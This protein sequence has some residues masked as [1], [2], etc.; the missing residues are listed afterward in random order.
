MAVYLKNT[1]AMMK[2]FVWMVLL[3]GSVSLAYAQD[4]PAAKPDLKLT[5]QQTTKIREINKTYIDGLKELRKD[6][7]LTKET[8]KAQ[9]DALQSARKEQMQSVLDKDQFTKWEDNQ[10]Q[11]AD[12]KGRH[13]GKYGKD[14]KLAR[15]GK[16]EGF[17][18]H[19]RSEAAVKALGLSEQQG[20][21]LK[22]INKEYMTKA[23]ALKDADKSERRDKMKSLHNERLEKVKLA[24]GEEKFSKYNEWRQQERLQHRSGERKKRMMK[25]RAAAP[26]VQR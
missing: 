11:L 18:R 2:Q 21:D 7:N 13:H 17:K 20:A 5:E 24:L 23:M 25:E 15:D 3:T 14:G 19:D 4:K 16:H 26:A 9:T 6:E 10:K 8:R 22:A 12:R 1:I